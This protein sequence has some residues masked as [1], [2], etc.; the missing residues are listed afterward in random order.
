MRSAENVVSS[1]ASIVGYQSRQGTQNDSDNGESWSEE[2]SGGVEQ[3]N[4]GIVRATNEMRQISEAE[5][6]SINDLNSQSTAD[7]QSNPP[8]SSAP[9][10]PSTEFIQ[11]LFDSYDPLKVDLAGLDKPIA[12]L[13]VKWLAMSYLED[14]KWADAKSS[15]HHLLNYETDENVRWQRMH[16]L[17]EACLGATEFAEAE[18]WCLAALQGRQASM[19]IRHEQF[20]ESVNLLVQIYKIMG[21]QVNAHEHAVLH[22]LPPGLEGKNSSR[23]VI[24]QRVHCDR[25]AVQSRGRSCCRTSW[26]NV[27]QTYSVR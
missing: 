24:N 26:E 23:V 4:V 27:L 20:Y 5:E 3:W 9:A 1:A 14:K 17:A 21:K 25:A 8:L 19:G 6:A 7:D 16:M 15:L 18:N 13:P 12:D 2:R 10:S 11:N 22:Q